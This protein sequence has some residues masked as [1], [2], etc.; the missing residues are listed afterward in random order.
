MA[1]TKDS[2]NEPLLTKA[3]AN[4]LRQLVRMG[5][6]SEGLTL[7]RS[8][9]AKYD[10]DISPSMVSVKKIESYLV[11][12]I[13]QALMTVPVPQ[14]KRHV[15]EQGKDGKSDGDSTKDA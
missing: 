15:N 9:N 6:L 14:L 3:Q 11:D 2:I 13:N 7:L 8:L 1:I 4:V 12:Q 5:Q 10:V